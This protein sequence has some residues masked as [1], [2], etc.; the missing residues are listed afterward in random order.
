V[1]D[2]ERATDPIPEAGQAPTFRERIALAAARMAAPA[3]PIRSVDLAGF[4][5]VSEREAG[6]W[7]CC[8]PCSGAMVTAWLGAS[9]ATLEAAHLIRTKAGRPHTGGMSAAQLA[10]G[11]ARAFGVE[12]EAVPRDGPEISARLREGWAIAVPLTAG[13][14]PTSLR[15]W[16][17]AFTGG[18]MAVLAG[19][20]GS[21]HWGWWDP[22]APAGWRG[23]YVLQA[24]ILAALWSTGIQGAPRLEARD[25]AIN[26]VPFLTGVVVDLA[27]GAALY[28]RADLAGD[29]RL[30]LGSPTEIT[31]V[32]I[33]SAE[34][35]AVHV[36]TGADRY[37]ILYAHRG[38]TPRRIADPA[39]AARLEG[40][41]IEWARWRDAIAPIDE[42]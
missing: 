40:R 27:R 2:A 1:I 8:A 17:P 12:L 22:L 19:I 32:G 31:Y 20:D 14:L 41:R 38:P 10:I 28:D 6:P 42:P 3:A 9:P 21:G 25:V 7:I 15:R 23:E 33:V 16:S 13:R 39:G 5:H 11:A 37:A 4:R 18:H 35:I 24:P 36:P 30:T 26:A 29:P 34:A